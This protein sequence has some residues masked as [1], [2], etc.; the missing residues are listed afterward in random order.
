MGIMLM[1]ILEKTSK[2]RITLRLPTDILESLKTDACKKDLS[3]NVL[4]SNML[5]KNIMYDETVNLILNI[6]I[7]YDLL[8]VIV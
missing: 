5:S 7:P 8:S 2:S 1:E 3:L 4:I 6:I